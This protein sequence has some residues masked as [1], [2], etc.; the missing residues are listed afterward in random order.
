M[1]GQDGAAHTFYHKG[2]ENYNILQV[3][4]P[5]ET[6]PL[7]TIFPE[8]WP[9]RASGEYTKCHGD[10][11]HNALSMIFQIVDHVHFH[12]I[13]KPADGGDKEGLVIGWPSRHRSIQRQV[14]LAD[15]F[16]FVQPRKL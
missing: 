10:A 9:T 8:Q 15:G 1:K 13:P 4:P 12:V 7:L 14:Y 6:V 2:A 11:V 16:L 5:S 3:R